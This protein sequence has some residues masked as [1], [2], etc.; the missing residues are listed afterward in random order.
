M[1]RGKGRQGGTLPANPRKAIPLLTCPT[2]VTEDFP[3]PQTYFVPHGKRQA[4]G[5]A[6]VDPRISIGIYG[7]VAVSWLVPDPRIERQH[8]AEHRGKSS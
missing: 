6:F 4:I 3:S 8:V 2:W 5:L 7:L 1:D